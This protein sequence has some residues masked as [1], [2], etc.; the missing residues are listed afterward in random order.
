MSQKYKVEKKKEVVEE[1]RSVRQCTHPQRTRRQESAKKCA[2][3][4]SKRTD[5]EQLV[6]LDKL[7]GKNKG[8]QK[9]RERLK[10]RIRQS[11]E[12]KNK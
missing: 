7:L 12:G 4:R 3:A 9:E 5:Q 2:K 1:N 10:D 8:A 11:K 6:Q